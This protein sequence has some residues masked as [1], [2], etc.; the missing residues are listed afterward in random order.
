MAKASSVVPKSMTARFRPTK[1]SN[2]TNLHPKP[3]K[4]FTVEN[5]YVSAL[6]NLPKPSPE[7]KRTLIEF[8]NEVLRESTRKRKKQ[9]IYTKKGKINGFMAFRAFYSRSIFSSER[10]RQLSVLLSKVWAKDSNQGVWNRYADEYNKD[11][12]KLYFVE[13]LCDALSIEVKSE[14]SHQ[15]TSKEPSRSG[16]VEDIFAVTHQSR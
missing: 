14:V 13:W 9:T 5:Y 12:R 6:P 7:L 3:P 4:S 1:K 2:K 16:E 8:N 15:Y 10:Q 11:E